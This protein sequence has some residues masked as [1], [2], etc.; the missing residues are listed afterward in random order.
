[1]KKIF[2]L[3]TMILTVHSLPAQVAGNSLFQPLFLY[4]NGPGRILPAY[5]GEMLR[6]DRRYAIEAVPA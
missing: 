6:V 2:L 1:M 3:L 4:T 5:H